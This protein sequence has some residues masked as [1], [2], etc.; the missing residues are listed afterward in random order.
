MIKR[1]IKLMFA[2]LLF[3]FLCLIHP[4]SADAEVNVNINIGPPPVFEIPAPPEVLVIPGTYAY[5]VPDIDVDIIFY[6]GYWYRP[7][8]DHWYR[9]SSY[10]GPWGYI[11]RER[12]PVVILNLPPDY[13]HIPPR[14]SRIPY[15][16]LKENWRGWEKEKHWD[17]EHR[18]R[19]NDDDHEGRGKGKGKEKHHHD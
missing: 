18:H 12:V 13:R 17:D 14:H 6:H 19:D 8:R 2:S 1:T 11:V 10:N 16:H 15:G 9:A 3:M 5:F 7:H 4:L